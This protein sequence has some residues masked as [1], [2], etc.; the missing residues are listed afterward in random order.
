MAHNRYNMSTRGLPDMNTLS[1]QA[2][3][4]RALGVNIRQTFV[5]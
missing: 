3:G 5:S 2:Y 1:S 4:H